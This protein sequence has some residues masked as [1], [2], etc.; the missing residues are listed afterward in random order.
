MPLGDK[1]GPLGE[2]P[3]TGMGMGKC[4][5]P[6]SRESTE[7]R[8]L[9]HLLQNELRSESDAGENYVTFAEQVKRAGLD[10]LSETLLGIAADER[11]HKEMLQKIVDDLD[12][13][14]P[15]L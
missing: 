15:D 6:G 8:I 14:C 4:L 13:I 10:D 3:G 11:R 9:K 2:G 7:C 1:T 5:V 12:I